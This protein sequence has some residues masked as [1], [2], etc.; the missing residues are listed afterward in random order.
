MMMALILLMGCLPGRKTDIDQASLLQE[1]PEYLP[2]I[3]CKSGECI[4]TALRQ[5]GS[6]YDEC[7][8]IHNGLVRALKNKSTKGN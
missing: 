1:C 6:Q 4:M 8:T 3:S 2:A 5:W 7:K